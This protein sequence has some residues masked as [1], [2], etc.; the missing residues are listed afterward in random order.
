MEAQMS[1]EVTTEQAHAA[2]RAAAF[3]IRDRQRQHT[4]GEPVRDD[5]VDDATD[6]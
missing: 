4:G 1:D 2:R 3:A 6:E 5:V